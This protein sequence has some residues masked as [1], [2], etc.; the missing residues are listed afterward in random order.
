MTWRTPAGPGSTLRRTCDSAEAALAYPGRAL[1]EAT[2]VT[3]GRGTDAPFLLLGAPW[4]AAPRLASSVSVPGFALEPGDL[5]A[6]GLGGGARAQAPRPACAGVRVRV[7]DANAP[8]PYRLGVTLL[9]V[10]RREPGFRWRRDGALDWLVGTRAL[11][12]ALERGDSLE[13]ILAADAADLAAW[14]RERGPLLLKDTLIK[15]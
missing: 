2:N 11:R 8:P 13:A 1:L 4:L 10:L 7:T 5:H 3:E 15:A 9:H 12:Q 14:E 6:A